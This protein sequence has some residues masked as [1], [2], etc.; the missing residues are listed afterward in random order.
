M[1]HIAI[2][3][4]LNGTVAQW[5]EKAA[6]TISMRCNQINNFKSITMLSTRNKSLRAYGSEEW[7]NTILSSPFHLVYNPNFYQLW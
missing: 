5:L 4:Q 2:Q 6:M 3:E 7:C 1:T